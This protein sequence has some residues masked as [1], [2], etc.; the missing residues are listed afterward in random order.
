MKNI[1][2]KIDLYKRIDIII[3]FLYIKAYIEN[4]DFEYYRNIYKKSIYSISWWL[5]QHKRNFSDY[6][7]DFINLIHS[8]KKIWFD[9]NYP[10]P[11]NEN[12][13]I[14]DWA[15]RTAC[16]IYFNIPFV[17]EKKEKNK[18]HNLWFEKIKKELTQDELL[19]VLYWY[20]SISS[21][22]SIILI[23][24]N[25][26]E[27]KYDIINLLK[28]TNSIIWNIDLI[29][30]K[31]IFQEVVSDIY[32][33]D[34]KAIN[35]WS[36]LCEKTL[37]CLKYK[38]IISVILIKKWSISE[39]NVKDNLR[40]KLVWFIDMKNK[41]KAQYYTIHWWDSYEENKYLT[42]ILLNKYNIN[43]LKLR[44]G[45]KYR[46]QFIKN[47]EIY[48]KELKKQNINKYELCIVS[49]AVSEIFDIVE[50]WD[51]DYISKNIV[52]NK[53][54]KITK[55]IDLLDYNYDKTISNELIIN[56]NK[57]H[58][59]FRWL[60]FLSLEILKKVKSLSIREKDLY[61]VDEI[62]KILKNTNIKRSI[63]YDLILEIKFI[64]KRFL[65][66]II[67]LWIYITKKINI[68][69]YSSYIWRKYFL[70]K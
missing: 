4:E 37:L 59:Y 69:K 42:N 19:D 31:N 20:T 70:K 63:T 49:S 45:K 25:L 32:S 39:R 16:C 11:V 58:F 15:H 12:Y 67:N 68:Y 14:L 57:N 35:N 9:S 7:K 40:K 47:I 28:N 51:I 55:D 66:R 43:H 21:D 6:E 65:I 17:F 3:K 1:I 41:E 62:K 52:T 23:W 2:N 53:V 27:K 56:K 34:D 36:Q 26:F 61:Q 46:N 44:K 38:P 64:I 10:I 33:F 30:E 50:S 5:E 29:F 60:K 22:Y 13:E 8:F 54:I 24:P 48:K 18:W